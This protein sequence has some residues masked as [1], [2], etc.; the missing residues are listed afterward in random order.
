MEKLLQTAVHLRV[1]DDV[2]VVGAVHPTG[3][4]RLGGG[5]V[6]GDA[7]LHG[8]DLVGGAVDDQDGGGHLGDLRLVCEGVAAEGVAAAGRAEHLAGGG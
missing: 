2:V 1:E 7:V 4:H 8:D 5:L 6:E 3:V